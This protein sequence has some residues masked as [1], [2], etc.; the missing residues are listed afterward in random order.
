MAA[1]VVFVE[2]RQSFVFLDDFLFAVDCFNQSGV[3][4]ILFARIFPQRI[5][6]EL[7]LFD[8]GSEEG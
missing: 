1:L 4:C 2:R 3:L 8:W 7:Y 6:L 5:V